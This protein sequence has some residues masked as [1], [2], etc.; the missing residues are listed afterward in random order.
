[1][2]MNRKAMTPVMTHLFTIRSLICTL[3]LLICGSHPTVLYASDF[4]NNLQFTLGQKILEDNDWGPISHQTEF[5]VLFDYQGNNWP[6][7]ICLD[8]FVSYGKGDEGA[9]SY[10]GTTNEFHA[11]VRKY[12][13]TENTQWRPYFGGGMA[14][15][16]ASE[17][18]EY[19][20]SVSDS[21]SGIGYW[22]NGGISWQRDQLLLGAEFRISKAD[23][24]IFNI[25]TNIGGEHL[26]LTIGYNF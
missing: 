16:Y 13:V 20:G 22:A 7:S 14:F 11:G 25:D 21:G 4:G 10:S 18:I 12:W 6:V 8:L 15:L 23:A 9:I 17:T 24:D 3:I 19:A 2:S 5:G 26:S 1:M